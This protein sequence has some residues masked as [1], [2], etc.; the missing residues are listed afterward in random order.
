MQVKIT[1]PKI[2]EGEKEKRTFEAEQ[3]FFIEVK[4]WLQYTH[5]NQ[6]TKKTA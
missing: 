3:R 6:L 4:K 5:G 2:T 1:R